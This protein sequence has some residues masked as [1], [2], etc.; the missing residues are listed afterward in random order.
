MREFLIGILVKRG[1]FS[2]MIGR[3]GGGFKTDR[4]LLLQKESAVT[5][6]SFGMIADSIPALLK[7]VVL[8]NYG[9]PYDYTKPWPE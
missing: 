6:P 5:N 3:S 1:I 8:R 9:K 7:A 4:R 2:Y